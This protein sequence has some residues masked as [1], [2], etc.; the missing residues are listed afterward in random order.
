LTGEADAVVPRTDRGYHPL[1]AAY[2]RACLEP[3]AARLADGRLKMIDFLADVR[4]RVVT[5]REID[6]FGHHDR[7][8]TNVNTPAEYSDLEISRGR[9][10]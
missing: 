9:Q 2:T 7:L 10:A 6:A 8:L 3:A 4:V 1:Y 5:T